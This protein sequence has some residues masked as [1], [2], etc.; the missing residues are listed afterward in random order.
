MSIKCGI[1][2]STEGR[3]A[4][5]LGPRHL[6]N[7]IRPIYVWR[8]PTRVVERRSLGELIELEI[9]CREVMAMDRAIL[10]SP[11]VAGEVIYVGSADGYLYA[12][13]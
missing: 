4:C 6:Q 13:Y 2:V 1:C 9:A 8:W 11:V 10:S 12:I 7:G 3:S 5:E